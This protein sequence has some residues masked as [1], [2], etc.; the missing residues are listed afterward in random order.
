LPATHVASLILPPS[1]PHT[2]ADTYSCDVYDPEGVLGWISAA[3]MT[4][5]GLQVGCRW[6]VRQHPLPFESPAPTPNVQAGRVFVNY[7]S[8]LTLPANVGSGADNRDAAAGRGRVHW[9]MVVRWVVWGL[10]IGGVGAGLCGF[11]KEDGLIPV[12]WHVCALAPHPA[13]RCL[14]S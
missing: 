14:A 4:F 3:W 8:Q 7:R 13:P 9:G 11:S 10:V 1:S 6:G 2:R 5:L 12:R